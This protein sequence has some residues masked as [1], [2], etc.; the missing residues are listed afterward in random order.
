[1]AVNGAIDRAVETARRNAREPS[2]LPRERRPTSPFA[3]QFQATYSERRRFTSLSFS[4]LYSIPLLHFLLFLLSLALSS[5]PSYALFLTRRFLSARVDVFASNA[6]SWR[7]VGSL[8]ALAKAVAGKLQYAWTK[9]FSKVDDTRHVFPWIDT[10]ARLSRKLRIV[11]SRISTEESYKYHRP[12]ILLAVR[13][14]PLLFISSIRFISTEISCKR[15]YTHMQ[16]THTHIYK[17]RVFL[18]NCPLTT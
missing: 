18:R 16:R 11:G 6:R 4:R 5:P 8:P 10:N 2:K 15:V 7:N 13:Y 3:Y 14:A 1:M 12:T 9:V 17:Y